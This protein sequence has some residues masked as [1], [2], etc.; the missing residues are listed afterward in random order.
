M[1]PTY[2]ALRFFSVIHFKDGEALCYAHMVM[3]FVICANS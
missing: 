3:N 1:T 2:L